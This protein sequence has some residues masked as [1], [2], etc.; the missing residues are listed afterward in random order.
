M[1]HLAPYYMPLLYTHSHDGAQLCL[2]HITEDEAYFA[3]AL[4]P[5]DATES[6]RRITHPA[7]RLQ[8]MA[9]RYL[10]QLMYPDAMLRLKGRKPYLHRGPGVS[11]SHSGNTAG[12]LLSQNGAGLDIQYP[13]EKLFRIAPRFALPNEADALPY[14]TDLE[15]LTALWCIKESVF[16]WYGTNLPFLSIRLA[17]VRQNKVRVVCQP[18]GESCHHT[19]Y[20]SK[21]C[22]LMMAYVCD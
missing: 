18:F 8:H 10:L 19:A 17:E 4:K 15:R 6:L 5:W 20:I 13:D 11:I 16:K 7:K 2:W 12:V 9:S 21:V 1:L 3:D 22:G 14:P